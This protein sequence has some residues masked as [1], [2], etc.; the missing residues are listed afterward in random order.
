MVLAD[1]VAEL[2]AVGVVIAAVPLYVGCGV[3]LSFV[4]DA[5]DVPP[6]AVAPAAKTVPV[7]GIDEDVGDK[8]EDVDGPVAKALN[9]KF[10]WTEVGSVRYE[11]S[12]KSR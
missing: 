2:L 11:F 12:T 3:V 1:G 9:K 5:P 10:R 6:T 8:E 4:T 7:L